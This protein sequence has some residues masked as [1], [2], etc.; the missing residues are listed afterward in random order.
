MTKFGLKD[1]EY[2]EMTDILALVLKKC[3]AQVFIFGSR[4]KGKIKEMSDIDL[5][6]SYNGA[7]VPEGIIE[8]LKD[9]FSASDIRFRVD[10]LDLHKISPSFKSAIEK[11]FV[12]IN[13]K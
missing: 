8:K 10:V 12:E 6:L 7:P 13:Y 2:E 11:D 9:Y 5:A 1:T 4:A 3:P